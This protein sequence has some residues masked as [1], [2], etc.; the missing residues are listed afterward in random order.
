VKVLR[1]DKHMFG[2][3]GSSARNAVKKLIADGIITR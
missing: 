2:S 1:S 3:T